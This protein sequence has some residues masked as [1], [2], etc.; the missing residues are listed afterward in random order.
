M[1]CTKMVPEEEDRVE[2]FIGGP[3][4]M[5]CG[6]CNK[7]R[8]LT[9]D[10]KAINSTTSTQRGQVVNQRVVTCYEC[11]RQGRCRNDC[12]K[13]KDRNHR[14]KTRNK[15]GIG[16]AR[17]KAYVLGGGD[18]NPDSNFVRDVSYAIELA[19][20]RI[21]KTNIVLKGCRLGL[22]AN[23]HAVIV[24]DEKIV[25]I[26]YGNKVLI[27]QGMRKEIEDKSKEK[28][29]EDAPTIR[30]FLE[31]P[32]AALVARAPYRL[33]PS[34]LQEMSIQLQELSDKGFI[35]PSSSPWGASVLF[36]KKKDGSFRM[37]IDYRELN[38]LT[39]KNRYPLL[40]ID[41]LFD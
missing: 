23:H 7:V 38:K 4:T 37:C 22:L 12:P 17:G 27:V 2:K 19:D 25:R 32:G 39:V 16:K 35:R 3:C 31:V 40:R 21:S 30:D 9:R 5:R 41:D 15:N 29:I 14:N 13:L 8:H 26:P 18:A 11:G 36:A 10:F 28:R 24:C 1:L 6:K 33:T 34:E 20:E